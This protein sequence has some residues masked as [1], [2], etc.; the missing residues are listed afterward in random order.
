MVLFRGEVV[1]SD[2][3]GD[4]VP[5]EKALLQGVA[6]VKTCIDACAFYLPFKFM[7]VLEV[8]SR[9]RDRAADGEV[10]SRCSKILLQRV[11][12]RTRETRMSGGILG[13][14]RRGAQGSPGRIG[15]GER[16]TIDVTVANCCDRSPETEV[17]LAVEAADI[18]VGEGSK[19]HRHQARTV[20][21]AHVLLHGQQ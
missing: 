10:H 16:V 21:N 12:E 6:V 14:P 9:V 8:V 1:G 2:V 11:R 18:S 4:F 17:I 3:S 5:Q 7:N 20:Q 19:R 13:M 15:N